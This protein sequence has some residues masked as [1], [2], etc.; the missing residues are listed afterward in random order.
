MGLRC[1]YNSFLQRS[2]C[3]IRC[4]DGRQHL[5]EACDDGNR[6]DEAANAMLG[7]VS[8]W[9]SLSITSISLDST[10]ISF[11][12][13]YCYY[14]YYYYIVIISY[15]SYCHSH[16]YDLQSSF[17]A[18]FPRTAAL[19]AAKWSPAS[20]AATAPSRWPRG[21]TASAATASR[22]AA[23]PAT[24]ATCCRATAA[25]PSARRRE[26]VRYRAVG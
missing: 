10:R 22:S 8:S 24:T 4:G 7:K 11:Y 18:R 17:L 16:D 19:P 15:S 26:D 6:W 12:N 2:I 13:Y 9:K 21:A 23:R 3:F 20:C 5:S 14:Y 25:T 1:E